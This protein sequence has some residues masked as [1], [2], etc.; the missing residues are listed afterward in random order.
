MW[1]AYVVAP[2]APPSFSTS[3]STLI[4]EAKES[5]IR[6]LHKFTANHELA[7]TPARDRL[8]LPVGVAFAIVLALLPLGA[9]SATAGVQTAG[10]GQRAAARTVQ[11]QIKN[12]TFTPHTMRVK[13]GTTV[14]WTNLDAVDHTVTSGN[15]S[16]AHKWRTSKLLS[17]GQHFAV[18]FR[19]PGTYSYY[20]MRHYFNANMHG[21]VI[22]IR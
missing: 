4:D 7:A 12:F 21:V 13:A 3:S 5:Y 20:C 2:S 19:T 6:P 16:D 10:H 14:V 17:Q 8:R 9:A 1:K 15:D 18:T 22:V 11:I